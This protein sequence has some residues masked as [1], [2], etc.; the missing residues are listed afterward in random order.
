MAKKQYES[1]VAR[2]AAVFVA[3]KEPE[4]TKAVAPVKEVAPAKPKEPEKKAAPREDARQSEISSEAPASTSTVTPT[5]E[6]KL[7]EILLRQT[8]YITYEERAAI[9]LICFEENIGKSELIREV[10][11]AGLEIIYP[12]IFETVRK[13]AN[14]LKRRQGKKNKDRMVYNKLKKNLA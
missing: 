5:T 6:E 3:A 10:L 8:F 7:S 11:D 2:Q 14:K 9:D 1:K 4:K 12:N 13:Q